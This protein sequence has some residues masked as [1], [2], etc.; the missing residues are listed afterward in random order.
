MR[1]PTRVSRINHRHAQTEA[2]PPLGM[3]NAIAAFP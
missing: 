3:R 2:H 1:R